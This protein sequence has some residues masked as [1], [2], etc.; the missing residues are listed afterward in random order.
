M[1]P[2]LEEKYQMKVKTEMSNRCYGDMRFLFRIRLN[3]EHY[4]AIGGYY[5]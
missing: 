1:C 5:V 3:L 4:Q 2:M